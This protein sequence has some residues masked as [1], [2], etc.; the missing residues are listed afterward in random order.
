MK[1]HIYL[2]DVHWLEN[3]DLFR[4]WYQRMPLSRRR[5]I[6]AFRFGRD[7]RLSL[8]AG[9]LLRQA[10]G[11][12]GLEDAG[13]V[14][15]ENGKPALSG[16]T[17]VQFNLSHSERLVACAVSDRPV[18]IDIEKERHFEEALCRFVFSDGEITWIQVNVQ[19]QD[20]GFTGLWTIKESLMKYLGTGCALE[21]RKICVD[22]SGPIRVACAGRR[23]DGVQFA[24]YPIRDYQL[25]VCSEYERFSDRPEWIVPNMPG[26]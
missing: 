19:N 7:Q 6:D 23:C 9:L 25:T 1:N 3:G 24:R 4:Y 5:K 8:G 17:D 16:R 22:L 2:L 20:A 21:P 26:D 18:G 13:L 10:L 14:L 11:R 15:G 12:E